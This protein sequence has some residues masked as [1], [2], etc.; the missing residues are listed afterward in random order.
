MTLHNM[1]LYKGDDDE[2]RIKVNGKVEA[3]EHV[4]FCDTPIGEGEVPVLLS[5]CVLVIA[6][7][8]KGVAMHEI[9]TLLKTTDIFLNRAKEQEAKPVIFKQ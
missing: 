9:K 1:S 6:Q 8:E 5:K 4:Y 7:L 2:W 3:E